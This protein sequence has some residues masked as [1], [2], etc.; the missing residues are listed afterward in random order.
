MMVTLPKS[1]PR[2]G[3][4]V[5]RSPLHAATI[6]DVALRAGVSKST[7]A[8]ALAGY[9][10]V[11]EKARLR[12]EASA[13]ELGYQ[14]NGLA[15]SMITGQTNTLGVVIPDISSH[16]FANALRGISTAAREAG[17]ELLLSS[18]D[19]DLSLERRAVELL[20]AKRVDGIIVA[21][22]S[23]DDTAHLEKLAEQGIAVAL[24]DRPAPQVTAASYVSVD[25]VAA[26]SMAVNHLL[27]LGH[28][29]IGIV[30]EAV[31]PPGWQESVDSGDG[32][33]LR[34]SAARL[35]GYRDALRGAGVR[36]RDGYVA[37]S[38]YAKS[39]AYA[40]TERL[41]SENPQLTA[42]Y[43]TDSELSA[44]SFAALQDLGVSCPKDIS[45]IGFD[46]QEW[47][48]LVRPRL[49]VVEQPNYQ[50]GMASAEEALAAIS[51]PQGHRRSRTLSGRL[52]VRDSTGRPPS[53][54]SA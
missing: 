42:I 20:A 3:N 25:H 45:L 23:T 36:Y 30:T 29:H 39:S 52:I 34:P 37:H 7:A 31:M 35:V 48:T 13:K 46:D 22:V 33:L 50:L 41:L 38:S 53:G 17:Y 12:V 44:G 14:P 24:L 8:R 51:D 40:A 28:R 43:C 21:P 32:T 15:R 47:A 2:E 54:R 16:F 5:S 27:D 26:S 11:S 49:T 10:S 19:G 9:G 18:T 4:S 1:T 6:I